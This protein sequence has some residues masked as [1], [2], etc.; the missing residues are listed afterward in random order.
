MCGKSIDDIRKSL[1]PKK[2]ETKKEDS[3]LYPGVDDIPEVEPKKLTKKEQKKT[4]DEIHAFVDKL[5]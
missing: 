4:L 3:I 5:N 2:E 1:Q